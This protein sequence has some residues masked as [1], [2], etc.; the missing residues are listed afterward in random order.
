MTADYVVLNRT[1]DKMPLRGF[2]CWKIEKDVCA[3]VVY[4]AIK[5]GYRHFDGACDYGNEVEVGRG[6][7]K[8]I[9]EGIVKREDLFIVT[10]LWNTFHNKKNV[11]PACERQLKDW[12]LDYFDLYLVHFPIPLA[13][14]DPSQKYPPEWFKG[15]STAIE[16]ESSPMHECWAEMERLVNDGLSRNIGVCNFNTQALVDMLTYAKIKPAVLQI[17]LHPYLP[18]AELTKWV[19]SQGIHI[20]AYS[21]FGP[22][23]YVTL[24]E[25]GKRAAPLLEHDAVKSLADKHKVSAGQILLRWALDR[26]YV[27]IPKSVNED[28]MK[29]NF[30]VLDIK[31]DESDNKA[32]DA[33]KSNQRFNDP[34][35]W[36][37]LPLFA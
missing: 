25:H 7:K 27:V 29:A 15:N 16:I 14:V 28:R 3:D 24:G 18:Q 8:A 20:T 17:E 30:D 1:G 2:G 35:V 12:G 9:D 13:Y 36:F 34:L 5:V 37:D 21:S 26:E 6:I 22:A 19:K 32:L 23:S 33:L 4:K 31:L 10:K 11:R